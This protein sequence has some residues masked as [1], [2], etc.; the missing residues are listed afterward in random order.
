[1]KVCKHLVEDVTK[2]LVIWDVR[3]D[4]CSA[5]Y[6]QKAILSAYPCS[7]LKRMTKGLVH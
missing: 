4:A 2:A 5:S 7:Y 1:M 6:E 3:S